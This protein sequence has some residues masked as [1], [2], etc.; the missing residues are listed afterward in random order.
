MPIFQEALKSKSYS[1][2]GKT[3]VAIYY[4]DKA[5]AIKLSKEL[6]NDVRKI[7]ATPLTRIFIEENDDT[8][9]EFIAKNVLSGMFANGNNRIQELY[10]RAF[11]KIAKSNNTKAIENLVADI[12][13]KGIQFKQFNFDK[14]AINLLQQMVNFQRNSGVVNRNKHIQIIRTG[15]T[16]LVN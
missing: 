7:I 12:I 1:V 3:L 6:P 4:I 14:T 8:E 5:S 13:A 15:I 9:L 11:E 16:Q 2:L 10:K